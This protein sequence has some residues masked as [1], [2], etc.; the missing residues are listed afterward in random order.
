MSQVKPW[1]CTHLAVSLFSKVSLKQFIK[2][3]FQHSVTFLTHSS[4]FFYNHEQSTGHVS[5]KAHIQFYHS[6][7]PASLAPIS[8]IAPFL[9]WFEKYP[10]KKKQQQ[11]D[12]L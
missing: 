10:N 4:K 6:H 5:W 8:V 11:R 1:L 9:F 7:N 3:C 12:V 2:L